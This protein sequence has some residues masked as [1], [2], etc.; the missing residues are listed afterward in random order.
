MID[1]VTAEPATLRG[2]LLACPKDRRP[3]EAAGT[4]LRCC[5]CGAIFPVVG[6]VPV[7]IND[8][9]SAF[10]I[11]DYS[12]GAGYE[13]PSYGRE[14]D[15]SGGLRRLYHRAARRLGDAGSS[16]RHPDADDAIAYVAALRP[17]PRVLV[18]GSGGLRLGGPEDRVL[19]TDVA[20]GPA[21]DAVADAHDLPFPDGSFDLVIAVAVLEHVADP[22]RCAQEF[23]RVLD[24][25]GFVYAVTPF[26]QPVHMGAYDF[27]R[28]TPIGHRRLFRQFDEIAAGIAMGVGSVA[29][30]T[31]G[32]AL[33]AMS[34]RR[35]WRMA[36]RVMGL[37]STPMLRLLDRPLRHGAD[38]AGGC[39]FFGSLRE[40][41]P[42]SDRELVRDYRDRF[43]LGPERL[44]P[45]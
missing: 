22:W 24:R 34:G 21:V 20:F 27:T 3:L 36:A 38:A 37:L 29:A 40:G 8:E 1:E 17:R 35:R 28:F 30:W 42:V 9:R 26:L 41:A 31:F 32:S 19:N 39:W 44:P 15:R 14:G 45:P 6:G 18:I 7:L 25:G 4:S 10:A 12:E 43:G 11:A 5:G 33:Q 2:F 16:I 13:G 23:R